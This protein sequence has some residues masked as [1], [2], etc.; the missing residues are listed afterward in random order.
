MRVS[1]KPMSSAVTLPIIGNSHASDKSES[2]VD[3]QNLSMRPEVNA[4]DMDEAENLHSDTHTFHQLDGASVYR[5]TSERILK[6]MHFHTVTR[7]VSNGFSESVRDFAFAEQKIFNCNC[8]LRRTDAIQH[9]GENL[10]AVLQRCNFISFYKR[11]SKQMAHGAEESVVADIVVSSD[12]MA[13]LLLRR[14]EIPNHEKG[15]KTARGSGANQLRPL[16]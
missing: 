10:I 13:D 16:R 7:A 15:S 11:R 5:L 9:C 12:W 2:S 4:R 1:P 8:A 3:N 14:K 6:K